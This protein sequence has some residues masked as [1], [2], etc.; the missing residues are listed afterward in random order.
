MVVAP[1][2]VEFSKLEKQGLLEVR[3]FVRPT[4]VLGFASV[5]RQ[6][7]SH[8]VG[9]WVFSFM[10][11]V[12]VHYSWLIVRAE[13]RKLT[14]TISSLSRFV[15]CMFAIRVQFK[16]LSRSTF[17]YTIRY[18]ILWMDPQQFEG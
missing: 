5:V 16:D 9:G 14:L 12:D 1:L 7:H 2:F 13:M 3:F 17:D 15:E 4:L 8:G 6:P 10:I 18:R 11:F